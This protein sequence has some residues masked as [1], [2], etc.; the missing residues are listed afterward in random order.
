MLF[1]KTIYILVQNNKYDG[2]EGSIHL[3]CVPYHNAGHHSVRTNLWY[4]HCYINNNP[5]L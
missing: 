5:N 3:S 1:L 4:L 2:T